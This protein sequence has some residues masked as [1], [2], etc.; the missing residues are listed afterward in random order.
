MYVKLTHVCVP[1]VRD[2]NGMLS[3]KLQA[4]IKIRIKKFYSQ[5]IQFRLNKQK[6]EL[7]SESLLKTDSVSSIFC[8]K[9]W[10]TL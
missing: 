10:S 4:K 7:K 8:I 6:T 2:N 3:V 9:L 1:N 5:Q